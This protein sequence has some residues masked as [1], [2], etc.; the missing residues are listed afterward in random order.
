MSE[1]GLGH[2]VPL[3]HDMMDEWRENFKG[4]R[5]Q[6]NGLLITGAVD[7]IWASYEDGE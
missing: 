2:M 1:N 5:V 7:D 4:V 3:Q 6:K